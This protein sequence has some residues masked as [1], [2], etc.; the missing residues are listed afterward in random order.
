MQSFSSHRERSGPRRRE[1][2][3]LLGRQKPARRRAGV[4]RVA[5]RHRGRAAVEETHREES[6]D[7][8]P[9]EGSV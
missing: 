5:A 1:D 6:Q 2:P 8:P 4:Q 3:R 9:L 7:R